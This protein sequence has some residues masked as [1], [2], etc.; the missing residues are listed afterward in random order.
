[1]LAPMGCKLEEARMTG[2]NWQL[3]VNADT[4]EPAAGDAAI[5]A[6]LASEDK[7]KEWRARF[8]QPE[9]KIEDRST[10]EGQDFG[11]TRDLS[12][13]ERGLLEKNEGRFWPDPNSHS[14]WRPIKDAPKDGTPI[15]VRRE[16]SE[17][18]MY[19]SHGVHGWAVGRDPSA[20]LKLPPWKPTHWALLD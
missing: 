6:N 9:F 17:A 18:T 10:E 13:Q 7:I 3:A 4:G 16:D 2:W 5:C 1:M 14:K 11:G 15:R 12:D 8:P 19:W 20:G